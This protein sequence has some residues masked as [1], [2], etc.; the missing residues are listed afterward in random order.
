MVGGT[1]HD[2]AIDPVISRVV[3]DE[4][5]VEAE[6]AY[7]T[8][9]WY[10][11]QLGGVNRYLGLDGVSHD[12]LVVTPGQFR[13]TTLST[14]T[15]TLGT[16]RLY[17]E[18]HFEIYHAPFGATDFIAPSVWQVQA[19]GGTDTL[20]F[21]VEVT[22]DSG[23][24][25]RVVVLYRT[26]SSQRWQKAELAYNPETNFAEGTAPLVT[27]NL[28]YFVQAVDPTGNV[29]LVLDRGNPFQATIGLDSYIYLPL[30]LK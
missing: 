1:F 9:S 10:P 14:D 2:R 17:D 12:K 18:L 29:A 11:L 19:S 23:Q 13:A 21:R 26:A 22:D 8:P 27:G 25:E 4:L 5:Y 20:R 15:A 6:P 30:V 3:T 7:P 28:Y 24:V 16:Q